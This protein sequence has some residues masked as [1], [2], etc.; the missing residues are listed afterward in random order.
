MTM[1][2]QFGR[3]IPE[4][5]PFMYLD[6]YKPHEILE[7]TSRKMYNDHLACKEEAVQEAFIPTINFK[8]MVKI[9]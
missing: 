5:Y 2:E 1:L 8:S 4:P 9:K 7:A 6:G 3:Q